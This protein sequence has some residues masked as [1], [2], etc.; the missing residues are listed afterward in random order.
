MVLV[1]KTPQVSFHFLLSDKRGADK[2]QS[3]MI[4]VLHQHGDPIAQEKHPKPERPVFLLASKLVSAS[5]DS[6]P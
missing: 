3:Q 6:E 4:D 2:R 5:P 1:I